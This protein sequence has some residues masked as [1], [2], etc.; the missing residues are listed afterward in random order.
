MALTWV[1]DLN[2]DR[3]FSRGTL[4]TAMEPASVPGIP[5]LYDSLIQSLMIKMKLCSVIISKKLIKINKSRDVREGVGND[6]SL[7][8]E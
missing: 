7:G 2:P 3:L 5:E 8:W 6:R 4:L 1:S